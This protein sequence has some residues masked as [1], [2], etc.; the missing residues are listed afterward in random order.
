M[1]SFHYGDKHYFNLTVS[2]YFNIINN[3]IDSFINIV[4]F[5]YNNLIYDNLKFIQ[6]MK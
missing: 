1:T 4:I 6:E 3:Y 5:I 2:K